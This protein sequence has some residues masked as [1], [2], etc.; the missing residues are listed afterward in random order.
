MSKIVFRY[1]FDFLN[2]QEKWLNRMA[3]DGY[4]LKKCGKLIYVFDECS[5]NEYEY[6]VEFVGSQAYSKAKDYRRYL[7]SMGFHT[8]TKN[9]YLNFSYGKVSWRP[10]AKGIGQIATSPGGLNKEL[11][12]LE[13]KSDGVPFELHTDIHDNLCI[14]KTV[15]R[16]CAWAVF[17]ITL[18]GIMTFAPNVLSVSLPMAWLLRIALL[19]FFS[20]FLIPTVKY[21]SLVKYLKEE[22]EIY[23]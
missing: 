2:S 12:I 21:S 23:E 3:K 4:R 17:M 13:K 6:A 5:P 20:L 19:I 10:Y 1:F 7:E 15:R 16:A 18:L 9:I 14:Y 11:L 22:S 8:F